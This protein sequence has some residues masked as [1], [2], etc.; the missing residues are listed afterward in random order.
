MSDRAAQLLMHYD[1]VIHADV[2]ELVV[3]DPRRDTGI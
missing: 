3:A 2:D 1:A